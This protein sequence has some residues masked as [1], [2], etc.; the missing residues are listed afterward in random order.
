MEK[1]LKCPHC[2]SNYIDIDDCFDMECNGDSVIRKY[3]GFCMDCG[4]DL[5]WEKI[6]KFESYSN[7]KIDSYK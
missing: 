3:C 2:G 6:F 5:I 4:T 1:E 7:I